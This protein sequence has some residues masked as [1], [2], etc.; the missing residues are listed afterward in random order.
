[1]FRP[2]LDRRSPIKICFG[3]LGDLGYRCNHGYVIYMSMETQ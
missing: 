3:A 2:R 1:M